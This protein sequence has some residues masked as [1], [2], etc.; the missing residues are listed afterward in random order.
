[1]KKLSLVAFGNLGVA[2]LM[3]GFGSASAAPRNSH[4]EVAQPASS[5][6]TLAQYRVEERAE[7]Q[8]G[9]IAQ[10]VRSGQLTPRETRRLVQQQRHVRRLEGRARADGVVTAAERRKIRMEQNRANRTIRRMKNNGRRY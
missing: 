4:D 1:M 8:Q 6:Y 7:R 2:V 9:R 3:L 5:S 10:G